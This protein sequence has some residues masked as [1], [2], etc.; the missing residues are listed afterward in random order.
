MKNV[1]RLLIVFA[2]LTLLLQFSY[3]IIEYNHDCDGEDCPI[4]DIINNFHS[5]INKIIP[6]YS[7]VIFSFLIYLSISIKLFIAYYAYEKKR[8]LITLKVEL[9]N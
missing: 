9:N 8:T 2:L 1:N 7:T 6:T 4:C 3:V 5:D